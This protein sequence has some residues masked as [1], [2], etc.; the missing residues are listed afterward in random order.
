MR[1]KGEINS[2]IQAVSEAIHKA[3]LELPEG[4]QYARSISISGGALKQIQALQPG[5]VIQSPQFES[6]KQKGGYGE[7]K[8]VEMRLVAA[9]GAKAIWVDDKLSAHKG[10]LELVMAENARYAINRVYESSGKTIIEA[11]ILP[12]VKG[13]LKGKP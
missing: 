8:N 12:T 5:D 9:A 10:E 4:S 1:N 7:G 6:I 2:T 11:V 13:T 3:S